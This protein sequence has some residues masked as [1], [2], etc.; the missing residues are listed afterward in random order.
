MRTHGVAD[1]FPAAEFYQVA[2]CSLQKRHT[3]VLAK[4]VIGGGRKLGDLWARWAEA[5]VE[6]GIWKGQSNNVGNEITGRL[7]PNPVAYDLGSLKAFGYLV[8]NAI[9]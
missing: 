9:C 2:A 6:E 1:F 5:I 4:D 3:A 8:T 7:Q